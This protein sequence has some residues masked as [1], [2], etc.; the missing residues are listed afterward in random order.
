MLNIDFMSFLNDSKIKESLIQVFK[1]KS[2][3]P[4]NEIEAYLN[5]RIKFH[6]DKMNVYINDYLTGYNKDIKSS[7]NKSDIDNQLDKMIEQIKL[8]N[9]KFEK[10]D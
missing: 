1:E 7:Q 2:N 9:K 4:H 3:L 10:V 6:G 8:D 5:D